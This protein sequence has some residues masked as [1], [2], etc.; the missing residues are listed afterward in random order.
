LPNHPGAF[1]PNGLWFVNA[2]MDASGNYGL[3]SCLFPPLLGEPVRVSPAMDF[4]AYNATFTVSPDSRRVLY[5]ADLE[6]EQVNDL[7]SVPIWGGT[8]TKINPP[9][10]S[11]QT[12][13]NSYMLSPT[14][15]RVVFSVGQVNEN[16]RTGIYSAPIAGGTVIT[17]DETPGPEDGARPLLITSDGQRVIYTTPAGTFSQSITGGAPILLIPDES[18]TLSA[19]APLNAIPTDPTWPRLRLSPDG[20]WLV[21]LGRGDD[22]ATREIFAVPVTG[23]TPLRLNLPF[24]P[25]TYRPDVQDYFQI[26]PDSDHV[27]FIARDP[28]ATDS[29][30]GIFSVDITGGTPIMLGKSFTIGYGSY[31]EVTPDSSRVVGSFNI[32]GAKKLASVPVSGGTLAM[33]S[34][35]GQFF[36][37]PDSR[38]LVVLS[39]EPVVSTRPNIYRAPVQGGNLELLSSNVGATGIIKGT[40]VMTPRGHRALYC[41]GGPGGAPVELY[42]AQIPPWLPF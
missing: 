26:T 17:L 8:P 39:T 35:S 41:L 19:I 5:T 28:E 27:I 33:L 25:G 13:K 34:N 10:A 15:G 4:S 38:W 18:M 32:D 21:Y 16:F 42:A 36:I 40:F 30:R 12:V 9:L 7:Y 24:V 23:G 11:G 6:T 2:L 3:Y 37:T 31:F 14:G 22:Y 20:H 1:S 29:S